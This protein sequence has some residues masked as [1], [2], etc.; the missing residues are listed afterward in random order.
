MDSHHHHEP[1]RAEPDFIPVTP[2]LVGVA[3]IILSFVVGTFWSYKLQRRSEAALGGTTEEQP[4]E[5]KHAFQYEVGIINQQQFEL[6]T[7]AYSLQAQQRA[8]LHAY[9]WADRKQNLAYVPVE[10]GIKRVTA[11]YGGR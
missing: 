11:Q 5:A 9:G 10:E 8:A 4:G 6:E 7:R 3:I 1:V 2:I